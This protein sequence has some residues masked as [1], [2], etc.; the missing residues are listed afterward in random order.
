LKF[1]PDA[2][3]DKEAKEYEENWWG[4]PPIIRLNQVRN[5][6]ATL[7]RIVVLTETLEGLDVADVG[8][9]RIGEVA[10]ARL[11]D[12]NGVIAIRFGFGGDVVLS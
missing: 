9:K 12:D 4:K 5:R 1:P 8:W 10:R 2:T 6:G 7:R 11:Q 3:G